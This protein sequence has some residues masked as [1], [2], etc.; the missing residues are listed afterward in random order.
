MW[1]SDTVV[2]TFAGCFQALAVT[3]LQFSV[4]VK[5][6]VKLWVCCSSCNPE[7]MVMC[8]DQDILHYKWA[9]C[10]STAALREQ[11]TGVSP[12]TSRKK[13]KLI[14]YFPPKT[15]CFVPQFQGLF[16]RLTF[17]VYFGKRTVCLDFFQ[18]ACTDDEP[19][20]FPNWR[21]Q[22]VHLQTPIA[23]FSLSNSHF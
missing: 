5:R 8:N 23:P 13:A 7:H 16:S 9:N 19:P 10:Q 21:Q 6:F 14:E 4:H 18:S 11:N 12:L 15:S 1:V 22:S 3:V 20:D 2:D 17:N